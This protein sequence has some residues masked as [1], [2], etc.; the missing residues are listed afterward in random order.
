MKNPEAQGGNFYNVYSDNNL[1]N[2]EKGKTTIQRMNL[3]EN[4]A[5]T[6]GSYSHRIEVV[7]GRKVLKEPRRYDS[8][9]SPIRKVGL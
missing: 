9:Q 8:S 2:P 6:K 7:N 3:N 5:F 4:G 1:G